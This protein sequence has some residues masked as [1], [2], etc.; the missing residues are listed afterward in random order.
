MTQNSFTIPTCISFYMINTFLCHSTFFVMIRTN[1]ETF[2]KLLCITY[3][4]C[5]ILYLPLIFCSTL[6]NCFWRIIL[7][8]IE[9]K[10]TANK[11]IITF[12][13]KKNA[14]IIINIL[15]LLCCASGSNSISSLSS[16]KYYVFTYCTMQ[17]IQSFNLKIDNPL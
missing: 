17:K 14:N 1:N 11:N 7:S 12:N 2:I 8:F 4:L 10:H 15:T 9:I 13:I 6:L 3:Y 5:T 16:G